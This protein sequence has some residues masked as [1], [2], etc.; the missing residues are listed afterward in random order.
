MK[1]HPTI[2]QLKNVKKNSQIEMAT[3]LTGICTY[4][5]C[6]ML[7]YHEVKK[8][9]IKKILKKRGKIS[10]IFQFKKREKKFQK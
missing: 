5:M 6:Y 4:D 7:D 9:F 2:I 1:K 8:K 10:T 3:H